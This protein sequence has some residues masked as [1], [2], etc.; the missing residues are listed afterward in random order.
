MPNKDTI[1]AVLSDMQVGSTVALCPPA[2]NLYDGNTV[3][4]SPAQMIIHRQWIRSAKVIKDALT[5]GRVRKRLVLI[6]NGEPIDGVHH[7]STQLIT[8]IKQEQIAMAISLLDEWVKIVGYEP[9]RKDCIYLVR[10]TCA[11][12]SG[13]AINEIGRDMDGVVAIRKDT[14]D[15]IKDGRYYFEKLRRTVNGKLFHISH[16][17]FTR[18]S[19]AWTSSNS[20]SYSLKSMYFNGLDYGYDIPDYVIRS[21]N[22]VYTNAYYHG[23][24]KTMHGCI[25][26]C[27]QLKTHF[28]NR[29]AANEDINTIGMVY[30]EVLKSGASQHFKEIIE[31]QDA[32]IQEF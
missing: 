23:R 30:Y 15:K 9:K 27:W 26:P 31:V 4:A 20:I 16:H 25:T 3:H 24:Q 28:G 2:W 11:H 14:S 8:R 7:E 13:N 5:E 18:G 29:V 32:P 19:R 17:G 12:E 6:L 22:H 1:V 21:H 10:G